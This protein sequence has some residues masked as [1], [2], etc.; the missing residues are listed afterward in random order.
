MPYRNHDWAGPGFRA[1]ISSSVH[2]WLFL[3]V[4]KNFL[5]TPS[6]TPVAQGQHP[7]PMHQ[8]VVDNIY[9]SSPLAVFDTTSRPL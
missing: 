6:T 5:S 4:M 9:K 2:R 8:A 3:I 1:T 7:G